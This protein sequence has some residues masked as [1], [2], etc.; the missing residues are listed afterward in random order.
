MY[1][2]HYYVQRGHDWDKI[3]NASNAVKRFLIGSMHLAAEEE[4][5]KYE[6]MFGGGKSRRKRK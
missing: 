2:V 6:A 4:A 5:E 1:L 3:L